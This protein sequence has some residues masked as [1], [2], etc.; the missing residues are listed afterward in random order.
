[1]MRVATILVLTLFMLPLVQANSESSWSHEFEAGYISTQPLV[2]DDSVY[3]RTSGFWTGEERPLVAAFELQTGNEIWRYTSQTSLQHDMAPLLFVE[4]GSG[5]CGAWND[6]LLVGWTDGKL[7][8]LSP[9]DGSLVWQNQTEVD[10]I[11]ITGKMVL[12]G[13]QVI[14]PTRTGLSSFCLAD[15]SQLFDIDTGNIGWRNGVAMTEHGYAYGDED[16]YLHEVDRNGN[17]TSTFLGDGKIRHAPLDTRHGLFVHMQ[18]MQGSTIYLNG[19]ILANMGGS[20]AMP[21]AHND[22][23]YA[24]TSD[25]WISLLCDGQ[26]C[27]V[28]SVVPFHSNGELSIRIVESEI[29]IWAPS[30]TP[31]GG[32]GVFN[33]TSLIRMETTTFDTYG[34]AA[35]G[36]AQG[37]IALGNDAGILSTGFQSSN[38]YSLE[39][40]ETD[41]VGL[42][43]LIAVLGLFLLTCFVFALRDWQQ[44]AKIGS[45][46]LLVFAIAVVPDLSVKLAEQTSP[47]RDVE[48]DSSWPNE[49][50]GTQV[51]AIEINGT[52][53]VVGGLEPQ[54]S[55]YDLTLLGCEFLGISTEIEEQY[56]GAYLVSFNETVGDGWE[57]TI[58]G[59]RVPLG[60]ADA[61]LNE[62]SIVE[63]RPA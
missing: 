38:E 18:T 53:H 52:M 45:A 27:T 32:W 31:D 23:I 37:V 33:Q 55:V 51:I 60:M 35:P 56:L 28:D 2:V 36:F 10:I 6:L 11:G 42:L 57:F 13:D 16:G 9:T 20:P 39:A 59:S 1:M 5:A 49:W 41:V 47:V 14:V 62:D 50:K 8:A 63:W 17:V 4:G 3:V 26:S 40:T 19:S 48:W 22:R 43:H 12:D 30:N 29:E 21:L 44:F 24:A 34:T 25:E 46:F 54:D 7:T 61:Q 58:D 15:G